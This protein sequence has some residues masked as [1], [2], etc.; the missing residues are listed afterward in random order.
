MGAINV[1][2][3][4]YGDDENKQKPVVDFVDNPVIAGAYPPFTVAADQ[5]LGPSWSRIS[6]QEPDGCLNTPS[7]G[8]V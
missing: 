6:T 4:P 3:M 1:A 2:T 8:G 7:C 5:L